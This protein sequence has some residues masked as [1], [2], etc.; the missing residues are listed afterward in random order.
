MACRRWANVGPTVKKPLA[1][2]R[3]DGCADVGLTS[4]RR[5]NA[6]WGITAEFQRDRTLMRDPVSPGVKLAV[7]LRHL[8]TGD[9]YTTLQYA[10]R[11]ASPTI[12]KFVAEGYHK[13]L[14]RSGDA[15][16]HTP[17]RLV[18]GQVCLPPEVELSKCHG[19]PGWKAYSRCPQGGGSLFRNC[20]GF[21]SIV[22]LALVD[23]D[24]KF[25]GSS[26]VDMGAAGSTSDDQIFKHSNLRHKIAN[27][28]SKFNKLIPYPMDNSL[29]GRHRPARQ[30]P[31]KDVLCLHQQVGP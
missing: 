30:T 13:G 27:L 3:I 9:S 1:Q 21:H 4:V 26:W 16:P 17:R 20:K 14:S 22:L 29:S 19:C 8:T 6:I 28:I 31:E 10:F 7:T 18:A 5:W 11:V 2:R 24:S 12:E 23:G 15:V 25:L